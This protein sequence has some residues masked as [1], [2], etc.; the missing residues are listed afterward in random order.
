MRATVPLAFKI[1]TL[2]KLAGVAQ[3]YCLVAIDDD[4]KHVVHFLMCNSCWLFF[5]F[6]PNTC[7]NTMSKPINDG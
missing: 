2:L 1:S 6:S 7:K 4:I 5:C 3:L